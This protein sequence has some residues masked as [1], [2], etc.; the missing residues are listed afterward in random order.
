[1]KNMSLNNLILTRVASERDR[2]A[3]IGKNERISFS[4]LI[5]KRSDMHAKRVAVFI[6][7]TL[8][9]VKTLVSLDG[10]AQAICP[11]STATDKKELYHLVSENKFDA[12]ITDLAKEDLEVFTHF[13]I[14]IKNFIDIDFD[15]IEKVEPSNQN[16]T[17]LVPTSGTTSLPK[18]V[19]HTLESL[20]ASSLRLRQISKEKEIWGQF[21]D[22]TRYAGYQ[23]LLNSLLNGHTLVT[24]S[25]TDPIHERV[26]RCAEESVT[27]ISATPSQWRKILMTGESAKRIP[28]EQIVLGGE[29]ADQQIL[30]AL[31]SF[32]PEA[33]ITHTYASTEAGLGLS[34]S[35]RL[36]G[37]PT[38]FFD[39]SVGLS[40]ISVRGERLFLRTASSA[41]NYVDGKRFRDSQGWIDTGDLVKIEGERF[42]ITGRESG[43]INVG[44]DKVNPESVRHTLLEHPNVV[45]ANVFGKKNP[46]TGMVL[47][48]NIQLKENVDKDLAKASVKVFIKENLQIKD[49]PRLLKFVDDIEV[50]LTGKLVSRK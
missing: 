16:S 35:D 32:Y 10:S 30:S 4:D 44:G 14:Q 28:L 45:Q 46:I 38:R 27:H 41:S 26:K 49:Q 29:A 31:S 5:G 22:F 24:S 12:V 11:I 19:S 34:V 3:L 2:V 37:F 48:A 23:V 18:L 15:Y 8:S 7:D 33:K 47:S 43:I 21:Y 42:F 1:M 6:T 36:A 9:L 50:A 25:L 40:E 20:G 13:D 39:N 17:W